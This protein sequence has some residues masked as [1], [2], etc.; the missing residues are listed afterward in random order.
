MTDDE[1]CALGSEQGWEKLLSCVG[2]LV[3]PRRDFLP[4]SEEPLPNDSFPRQ[5]LQLNPSFPATTSD[6]Q[7]HE[8]QLEPLKIARCKANPKI[9]VPGSASEAEQRSHAVTVLSNEYR[10]SSSPELVSNSRFTHYTIGERF[11]PTASFQSWG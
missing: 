10:F 2:L 11:A 3:G 1:I 9:P 4:S 5:P 7:T 6:S 8:F